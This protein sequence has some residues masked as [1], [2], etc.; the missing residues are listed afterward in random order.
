MK[1]TSNKELLKEELGN[2]DHI[3]ESAEEVAEEVQ[4]QFALDPE[5]L[6]LEKINE[7]FSSEEGKK[8]LERM[9][10]KNLKDGDPQKLIQ[11]FSNLMNGT[12]KGVKSK[13]LRKKKRKKKK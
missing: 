8:E 4:K 6:D 3:V 1:E 7:K 9:L 12:K 11:S 5:N 10:T 13:Y 2:V